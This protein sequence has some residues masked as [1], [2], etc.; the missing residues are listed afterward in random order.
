[1]SERLQVAALRSI[2]QEAE[3]DPVLAAEVLAKLLGSA[4]S[5]RA[6]VEKALQVEGL[7]RKKPTKPATRSGADRAAPEQPVVEVKDLVD[8]LVAAHGGQ[9]QAA[10]AVGVSPDTIR[11]W[12]T[13]ASS[14]R[15]ASLVKLREAVERTRSGAEVAEAPF[16]S[17]G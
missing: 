14:V 12:S 4:P 5:P 3:R 15:A 8:Q 2:L 10:R 11:A 9:A 17:V 7:V 1:M 13:G 16:R 6:A